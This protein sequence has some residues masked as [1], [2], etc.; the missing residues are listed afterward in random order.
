M[1]LPGA[2]LPTTELPRP[3]I[4]NN[5]CLDAFTFAEVLQKEADRTPVKIPN[6]LE[7]RLIPFASI[8]L[9]LAPIIES[10]SIIL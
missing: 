3:L 9:T 1:L 8:F 7:V 5:L 10:A 6:R 4:I 2:Q